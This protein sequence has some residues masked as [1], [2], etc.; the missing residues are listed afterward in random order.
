[1]LIH[2]ESSLSGFASRGECGSV[3]TAGQ[4]SS[5]VD[6]GTYVHEK[7]QD[8]A[9]GSAVL[10]GR[11]RKAFFQLFI[12]HGLTQQRIN[13]VKKNLEVPLPATSRVISIHRMW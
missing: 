1:M 12:Q 4:R 10:E 9:R 7:G 3:P 5:A 11:C 6:A 2:C 8:R 13:V